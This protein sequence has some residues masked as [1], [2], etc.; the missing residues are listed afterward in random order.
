MPFRPPDRAFTASQIL[1]SPAKLRIVN[2]IARTGSIQLAQKALPCD[3]Q[4]L[5]PGKCA[6]RNSDDHRQHS[7]IFTGSASSRAVGLT[8]PALV[9]GQLSLTS[10]AAP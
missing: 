5:I 10:K 9:S 6:D 3:S 1:H 8:L 7:T 4:G 2:K